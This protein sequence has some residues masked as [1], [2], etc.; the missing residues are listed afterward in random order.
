MIT[1]NKNH[2]ELCLIN[3]LLLTP[4]KQG[5]MRKNHRLKIGFYSQH[6]ADQLVLDETPVEYLRVCDIVRLYK[7]YPSL[8]MDVISLC[9][10]Y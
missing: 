10:L 1:T 5:E 8:R 9:I 4:Q 2:S 3:F 7:L 6:S